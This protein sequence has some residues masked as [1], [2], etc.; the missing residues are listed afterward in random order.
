LAAAVSIKKASL[1]KIAKRRGYSCAVA[2]KSGNTCLHPCCLTVV[3]ND[4][5]N[6]TG[7]R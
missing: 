6:L 3:V 4:L 5:I 2:L 7:F 1:H